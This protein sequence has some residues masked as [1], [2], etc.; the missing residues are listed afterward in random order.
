LATTEVEVAVEAKTELSEPRSFN[1]ALEAESDEPTALAVAPFKVD[2]E[3]TNA[4][5]LASTASKQSQSSLKVAPL[6]SSLEATPL[7]SSYRIL[8][9]AKAFEERRRKRLCQRSSVT[10]KFKVQ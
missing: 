1:S 2:T 3:Q 4:A 9:V 7:R 10:C 8:G 5:A 6:R